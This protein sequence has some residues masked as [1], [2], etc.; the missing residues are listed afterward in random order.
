MIFSDVY[1]ASDGRVRPAELALLMGPLD[2]SGLGGG[3]LRLATAIGT[4]LLS[5]VVRMSFL[6][7]LAAL[8]AEEEQNLL[9]VSTH[10]NNVRYWWLAVKP[11]TTPN[12]ETAL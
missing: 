11:T 6:V 4:L 9:R 10:I 12:K 2:L 5:L 3:F 7:V 1:P 8:A